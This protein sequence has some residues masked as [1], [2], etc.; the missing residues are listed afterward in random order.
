MKR[1]KVFFAGFIFFLLG[2]DF[3]RA[4]IAQSTITKPVSFSTLSDLHVGL[5]EPAHRPA[6]ERFDP[7]IWDRAS[8]PDAT[9]A[10]R[11]STTANTFVYACL[12]RVNSDERFGALER[13]CISPTGAS[14]T[15]IRES[16]L[17]S[18]I[19]RLVS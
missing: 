10:P 7:T 9:L 18:W 12:S 17:I 3:Q 15:V 5:L 8:E 14:S 19:I 13:P 6:I 4:F 1:I 16:D 11:S 2:A